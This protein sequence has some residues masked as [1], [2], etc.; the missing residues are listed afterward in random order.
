MRSRHVPG[1][2][3]LV[4]ED[5]VAAHHLLLEAMPLVS[6]I[7][8][9]DVSTE[10]TLSSLLLSDYEYL[11]EALETN[12]KRRVM[13]FSKLAA[14][15]PLSRAS[16]YTKSAELRAQLEDVRWSWRCCSRH[17]ASFAT[18]VFGSSAS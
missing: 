6:D 10:V 8:G 7:L 18:R 16:P 11:E 5:I 3:V 9:F 15:A 1:P 4:R 17:A 2:Y 12:G 13:T 14:G